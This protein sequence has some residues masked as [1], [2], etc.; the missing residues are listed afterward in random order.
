MAEKT[1][2]PV[3]CLNGEKHVFKEYEHVKEQK[4]YHDNGTMRDH[5]TETKT[6]LLC[7]KCGVDSRYLN[8]PIIVVENKL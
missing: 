3:S 5:W 1:H 6:Y 2:T 7:G 4:Y 8:Y